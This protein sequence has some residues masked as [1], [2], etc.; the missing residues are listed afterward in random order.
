MAIAL[1]RG[2]GLVMKK[3]PAAAQ[4]LFPAQGVWDHLKRSGYSRSELLQYA[5][6][7]RPFLIVGGALI[8]IGGLLDF[9]ISNSQTPLA[10]KITLLC[11]SLI[12]SFICVLGY[13]A[14]RL[15]QTPGL[16]IRIAAFVDFTITVVGSVYMINRVGFAPPLYAH[17]V[18]GASLLIILFIRSLVMP[19]DW[20]RCLLSGLLIWSLYPLVVALGHRLFGAWPV[21]PREQLPMVAVT[22]FWAFV[23]SMALSTIGSHMVSELR[24]RDYQ[25]TLNQRY[26]LGHKLGSGGM[27]EVYLAR[28]GTL[29]APCAIKVCRVPDGVDAPMMFRRFEQEARE[30]SRLTHPNI[31]RIFDYGEMTDGTLYF[32]MELLS[33]IDLSGYLSNFGPMNEARAVYVMEQVLRALAHAHRAGLVH[34]D[35]KPA[36]IFL[37][38]EGSEPDMVKVLDFGL[39]KVMI[40]TNGVRLTMSGSTGGGTP[41][42]MAPEQAQDKENLDHRADLYAVGVVFYELVS[43]HVP[44]EG[45]D[46]MRVMLKQVTHKPRPILEVAPNLSAEFAGLIMKLLEKLPEERFPSAEDTRLALKTLPTYGLWNRDQSQKWWT[47]HP[48]LPIQVPDSRDSNEVV[49]T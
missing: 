15:T 44:I 9:M 27:G 18:A 10:L 12:L 49:K 19:L 48:L 5:E 25:A 16:T 47:E 11:H 28:H 7:V 6:R 1:L 21:L 23:V 26:V 33:G 45:S 34:R 32:A 36:N 38:N 13:V 29:K 31:V 41:W 39:A 20:Q 2:L 17:T 22:V 4:K 30:V 24:K 35:L 8:P 3:T 40:P 46:P 37:C 42:Y 14:L 43:G